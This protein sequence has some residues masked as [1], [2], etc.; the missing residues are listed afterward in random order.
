[1]FNH[2]ELS[3]IKYDEFVDS[4]KKNYRNYLNVDFNQNSISEINSKLSIDVFNFIN[5]F[6]NNRFVNKITKIKLKENTLKHFIVWIEINNEDNFV[7]GK[8][9][10]L[11]N[12]FSK[13]KGYTMVYCKINDKILYQSKIILSLID[14]FIGRNY[15]YNLDVFSRVNFVIAEK[16]YESINKLLTP[17]K[18]F[19]CMGRDVIIPSSLKNN[20]FENILVACHNKDILNNTIIE[21]KV[22]VSK[23]N[24]YKIINNYKSNINVFISAGR[25]GLGIDLIKSLL[26]LENCNLIVIWCNDDKMIS[27]SD[28]LKKK[29]TINKS[30]IFNEHPTTNNLTTLINFKL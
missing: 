4:P 9:I 19:V 8:I 21:N 25:K 30:I 26:K 2:L 23:Q 20:I 22:C 3:K 7:N 16:I 12:L 6:I 14:K 24:Y 1:M 10:Q 13:N 27:D 29:Y 5:N 11:L 17:S 18:Y 28:M 15:E